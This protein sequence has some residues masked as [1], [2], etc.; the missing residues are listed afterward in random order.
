MNISE[1]HREGLQ[2][3]LDLEDDEDVFDFPM[4]GFGAGNGADGGG[5]PAL[6]TNSEVEQ[7][8]RETG[9]GAAV[10]DQFRELTTRDVKVRD[11]TGSRLDMRNT[12]RRLAGDTTVDDVFERSETVDLGDRTVGIALDM[13]SSMR[14]GELDAKSA[15]GALCHASQEIG[16][17]I[18]LVSYQG[19]SRTTVLTG[20][21]ERWR[22]NDLDETSPAGGT[23]TSTGVQKTAEL[24][25]RTNT[26]E[27]IL[28]VVTDGNP[29][30]VSESKTAVEKARDQG[31]GVIGV[32][33]GN[34]SEPKLR[35]SFGRDGYVYTHLKDLA[36]ALVETYRQQ[37]DL[38][39]MAI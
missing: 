31:H 17:T 14:K 27:S 11:R 22:W 1:R 35:R 13:S 37:T 3:L 20:P 33:F 32:G 23:P 2:W 36:S 34:V 26:A 9:V 24:M 8:V 18:V 6:I 28:F 29:N 10:R 38:V 16:D 30:S 21:N 19:G 39:Q 5:G 15:V 7:H 12:I 4:P 25:D